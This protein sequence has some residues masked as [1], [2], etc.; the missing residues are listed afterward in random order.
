M[1]TTSLVLGLLALIVSWLSVIGAVV[2][3]LAVV[4]GIVARRKMQPQGLSVAGI[5]TGG[6]GLVIS[7]YLATT[8]GFFLHVEED[9]ACAQGV[10]ETT[11]V[12]PDGPSLQ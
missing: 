4:L 12:P 3:V 10:Q 5:T 1:A 8:A 2:S 6:L 7:I 9:C 11:F